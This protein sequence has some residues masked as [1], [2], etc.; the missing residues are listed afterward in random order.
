MLKS[1]KKL[2]LISN[3]V[4]VLI[5]CLM[6]TIACYSKQ[7]PLLM[8]E[9]QKGIKDINSEVKKLTQKKEIKKI[10]P[11]VSISLNLNECLQL[12]MKNNIEIQRSITSYKKALLTYQNTMFQFG[13][14]LGSFDYQQY[15]GYQDQGVSQEISNTMSQ[16]FPL[17][18]TISL[19]NT[20]VNS[21]NDADDKN[22]QDTASLTLTQSLIGTTRLSNN[23]TI[24]S[25]TEALINARLALNDSVTSKLK[26]IQKH[27]FSIIFEQ[28]A[29]KKS[30]QSFDSIQ[31]SFQKAQIEYSVGE[32]SRFDL[33]NIKTQE[34]SSNFS[35]KQQKTNLRNSII[36][37]KNELSINP[38]T[39]LYIDKNYTDTKIKS[40]PMNNPRSVKKH[41]FNSLTKNTD[42]INGHLKILEIERGLKIKEKANQ[43]SLDLTGNATYTPH[44]HEGDS[45]ISLKLSQ[46]LDRRSNNTAIKNTILHLNISKEN[47]LNNCLTTIRET[48]NSLQTVYDNYDQI[49]LSKRKL[50]LTES[51]NTASEIKFKYG[52]ISSVDL[53]DSNQAYLDAIQTLRNTEITYLSS[54][55]DFMDLT[56]TFLD[57]KINIIKVSPEFEEIIN[58]KKDRLIMP[59]FD[60]R[61]DQFDT[62]NTKEI[63]HRLMQAEIA[64]S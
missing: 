55:Y 31:K 38:K 17:G 11:P 19:N 15:Y 22:L 10:K 20:A 29:L 61:E 23:N 14:S 42:L 37:M 43:F 6:A 62:T 8:E 39:E 13:F 40:P 51:T 44:I 47:F 53:Q 1:P 49:N 27:Y 60:I 57:D 18:T 58:K 48:K 50:E 24:Q 36:K 32:I 26:H 30:K 9:Y 21:P 45:S 4:S 28:D 34:I 5:C 2:S 35:L 54:Y 16:T 64:Y 59:H 46:P 12:A 3:K 63:C 7:M 52:D 25:A 56:H 33:E 41:I